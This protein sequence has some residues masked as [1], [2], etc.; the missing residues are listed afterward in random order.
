MEEIYQPLNKSL[1]QV[2]AL[3]DA[4]E[5][6]GILCGL[7]CT[8]KPFENEEWL[9]HV[10]GQTAVEDGLASKCEQQLLLLKNYTRDQLNSPQCEFMPLLPGDN[11]PLSERT[12][13]LGGWCEGFMFGL[14]L[15]GIEN[16]PNNAKEFIDDLVSISRIAPAEESNENEENYMQVFEYIRVCILNLYEEVTHGQERI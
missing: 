15:T 12:Q 5:A 13:A 8:L 7:L 6:H 16:L 14:A 11:I 9:K 4:A 3:M 10:L 1:Q 2:G